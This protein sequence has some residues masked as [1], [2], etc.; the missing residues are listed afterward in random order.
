MSAP[1]KFKLMDPWEASSSAD[2]NWELCVL[3]QEQTA[4]SL[5]CPLQSKRK[6]V[7]K[8]YQSLAENLIKFK[9]LSKLPTAFFTVK[10]GQNE[11]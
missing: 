10:V 6:D 5:I 8:G 1:K 4:E 9:E 7:G 11:C 3:C 2:V